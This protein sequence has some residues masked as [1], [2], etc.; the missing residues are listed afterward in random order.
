LKSLQ[1]QLKFREEYVKGAK[2]KKVLQ[3]NA[4]KR[5]LLAS[6]LVKTFV[7][8]RFFK[9]NVMV[10]IAYKTQE[11]DVFYDCLN[12][13]ITSFFWRVRVEFNAHLAHPLC[14]W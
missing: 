10:L 9:L 4:F 6:Q 5:N 3:T 2:E 12:P 11:E 7:A 1:E 8:T 13:N 14:P